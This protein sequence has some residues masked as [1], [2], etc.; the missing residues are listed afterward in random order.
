MKHLQQLSEELSKCPSCLNPFQVDDD[1]GD[2]NDDYQE[3]TF[4]SRLPTRGRACHHRIC[5]DC[6]FK[7]HVMHHEEQQQV[8][9][10]PTISFSVVRRRLSRTSPWSARFIPCP[11]CQKPHS[12]HGRRPPIDEELTTQIKD[13]QNT[14]GKN[15]TYC[16]YKVLSENCH[17]RPWKL[18]LGLYPEV[19]QEITKWES[20]PLAV[21][22]IHSIIRNG[23]VQVHDF[24]FTN[25]EQNRTESNQNK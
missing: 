10:A 17:L 7:T 2:S 9:L 24:A 8:Q 4:K 1:D 12:F 21:D 16:T 25:K 14:F 11:K 6:V 23:L 5:Q 13:V 3:S 20:K 22:T 19:L 18:P 15:G